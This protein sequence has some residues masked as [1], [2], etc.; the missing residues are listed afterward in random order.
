MNRQTT[1]SESQSEKALA[2]I[3]LLGLDVHTDSI[4]V[5]RQIDGAMQ[6]PGQKFSPTGLLEWVAR[7]KQQAEAVWTCY[8][9]GPFGYVLH[10]QLEALGVSNLV[11]CPQSWDE[12]NTGVK[13]DKGDAR[14]LCVRLALYAA[15]IDRE[16]GNWSRFSKRRQIASYTG[17]C[18]G[19]HSSGGSRRLGSVTK[20]G[21]PRLRHTL[22]ETAWHLVRFQPQYH[23]VQRWNQVWSTPARH[24]SARKKAIVAVARQ[25]AVDLWRIATG[26]V[27]PQDLGLVIN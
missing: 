23:A 13:T 27:Q 17:L 18:P 26:R 5:V 14:A 2:K 10:R 16:I 15:S 1:N 25:L 21:N 6:H 4:K 8:E 12:L 19:E 24:G 20:H 3:I 7:Q 22:I 9:A 11:V